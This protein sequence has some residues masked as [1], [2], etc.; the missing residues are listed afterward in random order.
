MRFILY[1]YCIKHFVHLISVSLLVNECFWREDKSSWFWCVSYLNMF[2]F[3]TFIITFISPVLLLEDSAA[4]IGQLE[5]FAGVWVSVAAM[6]MPNHLLPVSE[7]YLSAS[8]PH[9]GF[10]TECL[11]TSSLSFLIHISH[12]VNRQWTEWWCLFSAHVEEQTLQDALLC[13]C[14]WE[15][16]RSVTSALHREVNTSRPLWGATSPSI[17]SVMLVALT[18]EYKANCVPSALSS[19]ILLLPVHTVDRTVG[20]MWLQ[21]HPPVELL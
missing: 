7:L 16:N 3:I 13:H 10:I 12:V 14:W 4:L 5:V 1:Y 6:L 19:C 21:R 8:V 20:L 18:G 17:L 11:Y 9:F 2:T 15:W